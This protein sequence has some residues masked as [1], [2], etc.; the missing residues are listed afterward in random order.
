MINKHYFLLAIG[1]LTFA[2]TS[3]QYA[4]RKYSWDNLPT[5]EMPSFKQ[6]TF[7]ITNY[8]AKPDGQTLNTAGINKAIIDCSVRGGGVVLIPGGVWLTGPVQM[9]NNVNLHITR[10]AILLFTSD[11]NQY[12]LVRGNYEGKPSMRNL[13]PLSGT[14]LENIA[15]TGTGVIDGNG[16]HWRMITK[17]ALTEREW[18]EKIASGGLLSEDGR[19]WFPSEK[20]K[21]GH[22]TKDPGAILPS[23]GMEDYADVKD[24]LRPTLLN[25]TAC[26]KV[27]LEGVT[28]QNSPAWCLHLLLCQDLTM[29]N[30]FVKNPDYAQNGDGLDLESCKNVVIDGCTFDVGDDGIC[31]KSGKDQAGRDRGIPTENVLIKNSFVYKGH[32]GFVIGSEMSGGARNIFISDCSFMGTD[33]GLR[34]KTARGRGGIVEDIYVRNIYMKDI[35]DEAIYFDMYYFTKPPAKGEKVEV[36]AVS[37]E[38]PQF[39]NFSIQNV[40]CHGARKGIFIRGLPE[41]SVKNIRIQNA[42]LRTERG[43]EIIEAENISLK[44]IRVITSQ[45]NPVVYVESSQS[46]IVDKLLYSKNSELLCKVNGERSKSIVISNTNTQTVKHRIVAENGAKESS[47]TLK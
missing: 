42:E 46:I 16:D 23:K 38:T 5:A 1:L 24:Y 17:D 19:T 3:A 27:L 4:N 2:A 26:K 7:N 45:T 29:K 11:F 6:D 14:N 43:I 20:T 31:I 25:F 13:S 18:K 9:Q 32:G 21:K 34:F 15:I 10:S 35:V 33:K 41:M 22:L 44:D 28:F 36:P 30:V 40:V 37:E 8:G 39:R 12:P 47:V